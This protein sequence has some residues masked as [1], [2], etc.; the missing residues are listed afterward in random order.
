MN[1][2]GAWYG[3]NGVAWCAEFVSWVFNKAG[4]SLG[5]V[6]TAKGYHYCP[7]AFNYW[8]RTGQT[9]KTPQAG[10]IVLFDWNGDHLADHTGIFVKDNGNGTFTSIEGNTAM[11]ND[12][13]G[14]QVMERVRY[15]AVV[16]AFV[17]PKVYTDAVAVPSPVEFKRGDTGAQ[18]SNFQ[19]KL[20]K[21]GYDITVDG[22]FG[23]QTEKMVKQFQTDQKL[24]VTGK[25]TAAL[26]G[27]MDE[28][29]RAKEAPPALL[30]SGSYLNPGD[31]GMAVRLLQ[32]AL[33][34]KG[35]KP[36]LSE[37]GGYGAMT[38]KAVE[39]FQRASKLQVD[40]IAG[41]VTLKKLSL[42]I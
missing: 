39:D 42:L 32:E 12:S 8:N 5:T 38:K 27:A 6:D 10:D 22:D 15:Y 11:G 28:C 31:S 4:L 16:Q 41:P 18:V 19:Q 7:S 23:P 21:L 20:S 25:V 29:I 30:S 35:A 24:P 17:S 26:L 33:N 13:N 40:G 2:Y 37:D 3:I 1:K 14:G 9:T 34:K 36:K